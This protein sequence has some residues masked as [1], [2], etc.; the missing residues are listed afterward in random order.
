M[1]IF[2]ASAMR[3]EEHIGAKIL[4]AGPNFGTGSSREHAVWAIMQYGFEAVVSP[5]FGPIFA[6]NSTKNGLVC[7][8]IDGEVVQ[9]IMDAVIADPATEIVVDVQKRTIEVPSVNV[10]EPFP[11]SDS[12]QHRFL[13]GLDDIG[14]TMQKEDDIAAFEAGRPTYMPSSGA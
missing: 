5:R 12:V 1:G 8:Q 6:N 13:E 7:V 2:A 3:K 14:L 11:M 4:V 9:R 10:D